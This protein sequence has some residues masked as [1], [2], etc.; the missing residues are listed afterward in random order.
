[1]F[2]RLGEE[3]SEADAAVVAVET[4]GNC[5]PKLNSSVF[6]LY[7]DSRFCTAHVFFFKCNHVV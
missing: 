5:A 3:S 1:M 2:D 6:S 4:Q 7:H